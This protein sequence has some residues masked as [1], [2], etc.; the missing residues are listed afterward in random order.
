MHHRIPQRKGPHIEESV[1]SANPLLDSVLRANVRIAGR[2]ALIPLLPRWPV[3]LRG[4]RTFGRVVSFC[5]NSWAVSG[6]VCTYPEVWCTPC[7]RN[8]SGGDLQFFLPCWS[9]AFVAIEERSGD[10]LYSAEFLD[11]SGD[12]IH[13]V[14]LTPESDWEAFCWWVQINQAASPLGAPPH[15]RFPFRPEGPAALCE[16][17]VSHLSEKNLRALLRQLIEANIPVRLLV[18]NDGLVQGAEMRPNCL[19]EHDDWIYLGDGG[20]GLQLRVGGLSEILFRW[21]YGSSDWVLKAYEPEGRLI[22]AIAP[23]RGIGPKDREASLVRLK[24]FLCKG[25]GEE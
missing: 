15:A 4:M 17:E 23:S 12:V 13:R 18:G 5:Q 11:T 24:V 10:W 21:S 19:C 9:Q 25:G 20:C 8:A 3:L 16:G 2:R 1:F 6:S 7:G 22:C 14:C